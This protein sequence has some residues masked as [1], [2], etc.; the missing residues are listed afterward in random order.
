MPTKPNILVL[1][2]RN[3]QRSKTAEE[4]FK[5]DQRFEIRSA[6]V[7]AS[8]DKKLH[9]RDLA[10]ADLVLVMESDQRDKIIEIFGRDIPK[11]I[12]LH[13]PDEYAYMDPE[14]IAML[15]DSINDILQSEFNIT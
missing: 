1:C 7:S 14:L 13:I 11:I 6:G 8:A 3:K 4:I 2:G 10:W 9:T 12:V 5:Q 15:S